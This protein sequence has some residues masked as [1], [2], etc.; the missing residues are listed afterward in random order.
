MSIYSQLPNDIIRRIIKEADG[1]LYIHKKKMSQTH[2]MLLM[3][4]K[5]FSHGS[6]LRSELLTDRLQPTDIVANEENMWYISTLSGG[7]L[8]VPLPPIDPREFTSLDETM[9]E[10]N[11]S[12]ASQMFFPE[13]ADASWMY[14]LVK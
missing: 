9:Y 2:D 6:H 13:N 5:T 7:Y 8:Y 10:K 3:I 4:P 11:K 14:S 1:G 12:I